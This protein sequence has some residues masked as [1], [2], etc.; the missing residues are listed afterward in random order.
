[1]VDITKPLRAKIYDFDTNWDNKDGIDDTPYIVRDIQTIILPHQPYTQ[2]PTILYNGGRS[3]SF[4]L[5][6]QD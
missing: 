4:R 5:L 1:M 6:E 2:V 3:E